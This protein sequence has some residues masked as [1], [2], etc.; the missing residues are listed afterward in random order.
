MA[1]LGL[2]PPRHL[3]PAQH[4]RVAAKL[5]ATGC[6]P[7]LDARGC[8]TRRP[9]PR[10]W[11]QPRPSSRPSPTWREFSHGPGIA[12]AL[13]R[14]LK[15]ALGDPARVRELAVVPRPAWDEM[16]R[17]LQVR[18][19]PATDGTPGPLRDLTQSR[20][21]GWSQHGEWHSF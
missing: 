9:C 19:P 5:E 15:E 8:S 20:R 11:I 3:L 2:R 6:S 18:G 21:R 10:L 13:E 1:L 4:R 17:D 12:G 7:S 14:A 16:A